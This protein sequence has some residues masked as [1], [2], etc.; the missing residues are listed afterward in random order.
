MRWRTYEF[1]GGQ[2]GD[3]LLVD[4]RSSRYPHS[5]DSLAMERQKGLGRRV[6]LAPPV[7][8]APTD[9]RKHSHSGDRIRHRVVG[10]MRPFQ[11]SPDVGRHRRAPLVRA[12]GAAADRGGRAVVH[13]SRRAPGWTVSLA[14]DVSARWERRP[15]PRLG[16]WSPAILLPCQ[17]RILDL[18]IRRC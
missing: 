17:M 10:G 8:S 6:G 16:W 2:S 11:R 14:L 9:R 5:K 13:R 15:L 1:A 7:G 3:F 4:A 18:L 12:T